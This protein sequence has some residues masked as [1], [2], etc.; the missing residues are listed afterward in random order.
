MKER[1]KL[2][3]G[4]PVL[5]LALVFA[6]MFT[7][8]AEPEETY[9]VYPV[10]YTNNP[11]S[12]NLDADGKYI[13]AQLTDAQFNSYKNSLASQNIPSYDWTEDQF[14]S[15]FVGFRL[16]DKQVEEATKWF[17]NDVDHGIFVIRVA[18]GKFY[19]LIK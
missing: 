12:S 15:Y 10:S 7:G 14:N 13:L 19:T 16:N 11:T 1:G 2:L 5:V 17:I 6:V 3:I 9:T 4:A 8:C 18:S